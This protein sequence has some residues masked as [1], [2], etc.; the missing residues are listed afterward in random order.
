M[1]CETGRSS[2]NGCTRRALVRV[3]EPAMR[4]EDRAE[5]TSPRLRL[6]LGGRGA[7]GLA[8][9]LAV[10]FFLLAPASRSLHWSRSYRFAELSRVVSHHRVLALADDTIEQRIGKLLRAP[11]PIDRTL[12]LEGPAP[13]RALAA[14]SV[15]PRPVFEFRRPIRSAPARADDPDPFSVKY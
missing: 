10:L 6:R 15:I 4:D 14:R 12:D 2:A 13:S 8:F 9:A 11:W 7:Q 5:S 1:E 3:W